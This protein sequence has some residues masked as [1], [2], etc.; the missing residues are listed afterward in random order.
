MKNKQ[1][2]HQWTIG[3]INYLREHH[4][5]SITMLAHEF[6]VS[7]QAIRS[8]GRRYNIPFIIQRTHK[9]WT[10]REVGFLEKHSDWTEADLALH[11]GRTSNSI[12][13]Y[14]Q[15]LRKKVAA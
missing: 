7:E 14:K 13:Y 15:H 2:Y 9:R 10:M 11:L 5:T 1:S 12:L 6:K 4:A 3:Q 8:A